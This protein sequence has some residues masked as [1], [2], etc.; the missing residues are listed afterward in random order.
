MSIRPF[1]FLAAALGLVLQT[2]AGALEALANSARPSTFGQRYGS[3]PRST[4]N[5]GGSR[6]TTTVARMKRAARKRNNIR[7]HAIG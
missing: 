5:R 3:T 7:K 2:G 4:G 6:R 1:H